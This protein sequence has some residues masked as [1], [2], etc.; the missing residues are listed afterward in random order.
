MR[1]S[2]AR[3]AALLLG[4]GL[5]GFL[6]GIVLHQIA[7]W[8]QMLSARVPPA[9]M[10]AMQRNMVADGWFHLATWLVTLAG[11]FVLRSAV[12]GAGPLPSP[13]G[14]VGD[15]LMGWGGFNLVEGVIDHHLLELHHVRDLPAHVPMYDWAFLLVGGVGLLVLGIAL[16][17]R[18]PLS[19]G[20]EAERR[21]GADRRA[22]YR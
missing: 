2:R 12:R 19:A 21:S 11:V 5:G 14:F 3:N 17:D 8:H 13:R 7:H 9:T 1:Y 15:L 22:A 16:R 6:D 4:V 20:A 10:E 18:R